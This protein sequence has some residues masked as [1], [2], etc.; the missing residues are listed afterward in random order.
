MEALREEK[1]EEG[2]MVFL[3]G[4]R[5]GMTYNNPRYFKELKSTA[6]GQYK[7]CAFLLESHSVSLRGI[8]ERWEGK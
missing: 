6:P 8:S 4:A 3:T 1:Q 5:M 2:V 7:W